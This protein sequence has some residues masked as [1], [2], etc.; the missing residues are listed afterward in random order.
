MNALKRNNRLI[1][2]GTIGFTALT[3]VFSMHT[4]AES[5]FRQIATDPETTIRVGIF[6]SSSAKESYSITGDGGFLV[7]PVRNED[8]TVVVDVNALNVSLTDRSLLV[9]TAFGGEI[10]ESDMS[11]SIRISPISEDGILTVENKTYRGNIIC[12]LTADHTITLINEIDIEEYLRGVL[13]SEVYTSWNMEALKAAAVTARTYALRSAAT[14]SHAKNGFDV[15]ATTH[16]Q[17]YSGTAKENKNTDRAIQETSGLVIKFNGELALTPYHSSNGGYT[18]DAVSAWGGN[19][20][21]YPYLRAVF[22]PYEDYRNVPNGKWLNFVKKEDLLSAIPENYAAKLSGGI[23][24]IVL[25]RS[26]NG[27]NTA[28]TVTD[29]GGNTLTYSTSGSVRSF[30]GKLVKSANFGIASTYLPSN[31]VTA[32]VSVIT[33]EGTRDVT[34]LEGFTYI[35]AD[36]EK[37]CA[38]FE[39]TLVFDGQ[40][41]GHGVGLSQFG[42][43]CMADA[44]FTFDEILSTYF[45]GTDLEPFIVQEPDTPPAE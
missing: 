12:T 11:E 43:R 8:D 38:G 5:S 39:E 31:N 26:K 25:T 15:C 23:A 36:G 18:E 35:T 40:G 13:P 6:Y 34:A 21:L 33:S 2:L 45:P 7:T 20:S 30:F 37:Q 10:T 1:K 14:S 4:H 24:D 27:Y 16:C 44:G 29:T 3:L 42:S 22:T 41:Y 19:P 32:A 17:M 28:M 9:S